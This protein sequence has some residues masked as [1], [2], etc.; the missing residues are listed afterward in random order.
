MIASLVVAFFTLA[1]G[2][3]APCSWVKGPIPGCSDN[4]L[5]GIY[6]DNYGDRHVISSSSFEDTTIFHCSGTNFSAHDRELSGCGKGFRVAEDSGGFS[7]FAAYWEERPGEDHGFWI[8]TV[9]CNASSPE[10]AAASQAYNT[11]NV[12]S[13]GCGEFPWTHLISKR[14]RSDFVI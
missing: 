8:C 6:F 3:T 9:A 14:F 4:F 1:S 10:K 2:G 13:N 7:K 11:A 12:S 5:Q